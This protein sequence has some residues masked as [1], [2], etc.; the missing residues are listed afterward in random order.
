M[1][2]GFWFFILWAVFGV[3]FYILF[4][5]CGE[6][7]VKKKIWEIFYFAFILRLL[8]ESCLDLLLSAFMNLSEVGFAN[9]ITFNVGNT[10]QVLSILFTIGLLGILILYPIIA[11][12]I[13]TKNYL[14]LK[15]F[16]E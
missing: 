14:D 16:E 3:V 1:S 10:S 15:Q 9:L 4:S 11:F 2:S 12:G 13:I 5:W 6:N 7:K 8:L